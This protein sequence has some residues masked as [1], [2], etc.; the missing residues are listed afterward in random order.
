VEVLDWLNKLDTV[1]HWNTKKT[2]SLGNSERFTA[3]TMPVLL[4]KSILNG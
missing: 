3:G 1:I 4:G 2:K